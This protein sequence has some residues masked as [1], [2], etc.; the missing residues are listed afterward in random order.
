ML[1]KALAHRRYGLIWMGKRSEEKNKKISGNEKRV[2][3]K[4]S[5]L[6]HRMNGYFM[7]VCVGVCVFFFSTPP[8]FRWNIT[9]FAAGK[10]FN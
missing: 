9:Y 3:N 2:C 4:Y 8:N 6:L 5:V 10:K 1:F 7:E